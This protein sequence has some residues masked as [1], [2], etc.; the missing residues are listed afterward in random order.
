MT[1]VFADQLR[2]SEAVYAVLAKLAAELGLRIEPGKNGRM[3]LVGP[4]GQR[5][6]AW[7]ENYPYPQRLGR[8]AYEPAKRRLQI[9]LQKLQRSVKS[10]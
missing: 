4:D 10:S 6:Q 5:I 2:D 8:K 3:R 9:E 7:R 1:A